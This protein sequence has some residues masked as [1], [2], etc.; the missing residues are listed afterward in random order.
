M[1]VSIHN[2]KGTKAA[3]NSAW[4][5]RTP[6]ASQDMKTLKTTNGKPDIVIVRMDQRQQMSCLDWHEMLQNQVY[7]LPPPQGPLAAWKSGVNTAELTSWIHR[8]LAS[9]QLPW[10]SKTHQNLPFDPPPVAG[11]LL[12]RRNGCT[13][14]LQELSNSSEL[15]GHSHNLAE[16]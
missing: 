5:Q 15:T 7:I 6:N 12:Y 16:S 3:K 14:V 11:A 10:L 13:A 8:G 4:A 9:L 2:G 1:D